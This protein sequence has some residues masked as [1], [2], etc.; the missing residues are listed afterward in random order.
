[1]NFEME[2]YCNMSENQQRNLLCSTY[3]KSGINTI[4]ACK[5]FIAFQH[6]S[7]L[8]LHL[9]FF[10]RLHKIKKKATLKHFKVKKK[11]KECQRGNQKNTV[12]IIIIWDKTHFILKLVQ[13]PSNHAIHESVQNYENAEITCTQHL[14]IK[15]TVTSLHHMMYFITWALN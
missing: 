8:V 15:S 5:L 6:S 1:M 10:Q 13:C 4:S 7:C 12:L 14:C 11:K 3:C 2:L 9:T